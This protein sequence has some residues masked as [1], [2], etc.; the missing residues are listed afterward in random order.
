MAK[1]RPTPLNLRQGQTVYVVEFV[2][3]YFEMVELKKRFLY[4]DKT[5]LPPKGCRIRKWPVGLM[6]KALRIF[7]NE[8][9]FFSRRKALR[10]VEEINKL[11]RECA[12]KRFEQQLANRNFYAVN[13]LY[14]AMR[15][16]L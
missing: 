14:G 9:I 7:G 13:S 3:E 12:T 10:E 8:S 4:S 5:F 11:A 15:K 2:S 16:I 6:K 1:K